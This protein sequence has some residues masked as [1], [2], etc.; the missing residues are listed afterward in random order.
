M[1]GQHSRPAR[2]TSHSQG[3]Q[4]LENGHGSFPPPGLRQRIAF[5]AATSSVHQQG[6]STTA[7]PSRLV[8][9]ARPVYRTTKTSQKLTLFPDEAFETST[10][11][12]N[13]FYD[14][15]D[16]YN[17]LNQLIEDQSADHRIDAEMW[18]KLKRDSLPRVSA[19][20]TATSYNTK[21]MF[22]FLQSRRA[23]RQTA[24]KFMDECLYSPYVFPKINTGLSASRQDTLVD[25]TPA[26][27][28]TG[29]NPTSQSEGDMHDMSHFDQI[30]DTLSSEIFVFDYGV[31]VFWA[32][33]EE[34]E[35]RAL[36]EL[37]EY[38][39]EPLEEDGIETDVF[40]LYY[41]PDFPPMIYNDVIRLRQ[42]KNYMVKLA[43]S[44]A[45]AQ[46]VKLA[47]Y[48]ELVEDTIN[49][50]KHIPQLMAETGR[51]RMSRSAITK[52]IGQLFIMRIN[53]NLVSNILDT[54]EI[55]WSEPSLQPLY[56]A[57]RGYLEISQRVEIMNHRV[58][59]ISDLLDM[60][61]EHLNGYHGEFLE[62]IVII[63]IA[64]EICIGL[65]TIS[66]EASNLRGHGPRS[67]P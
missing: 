56:D 4:A 27:T 28:V 39:V 11:T 47:L 30:K 3:Y 45:I 32:M 29:S 31:I 41:N 9:K 17:Q 43:I 52:K 6:L 20:C 24:P 23:Q 38:R 18:R 50:T 61:R 21:T 51:V 13:G 67:L 14:G 34:E 57:I 1:A 62:W 16:V 26:D 15:D 66:L 63:L 33:T 60:L 55:F 5:P 2:K 37:D 25:V 7:A 36:M 59:V 49:D 53:V 42:P 35:Q 58:S 46:S 8:S 44:H 22:H 48:E 54:P 40:N 10:R 64:I 12:P 65:I 19:F